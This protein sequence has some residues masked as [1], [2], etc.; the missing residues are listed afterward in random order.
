MES[1]LGNNTIVILFWILLTC[2]ISEKNE[3]FICVMLSYTIVYIANFCE[4]VPT[5]ATLLCLL[6]TLF[7][8]FELLIDEV[9]RTILLKFHYMVV[10]FC[11]ILI[12]QYGLIPYLGS[13]FFT[14]FIARKMIPI[15]EIRVLISGILLFISLLIVSKQPYAVASFSK[16]KSKIDNILSFRTF[17]E[18]HINYD[19]FMP[20]LYIEDKTFISRGDSYSILNEHFINKR[21]FRRYLKAGLRYL[22]ANGIKYTLYKFLRGYSTIEMQLVRTLGIAEGYDKVVYRKIYEFLYV[23]IFLVSLRNYYEK[24]GLSTDDYKYFLLYIYL[25]VAPPLQVRNRAVIE[26]A[27]NKEF[28]ELE[29]FTK[30]EIFVLG[31]TFS[32]KLWRQNVFDLYSAGIDK[33]KLDYKTLLSIKEKIIEANNF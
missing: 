11:Y 25:N 28:R 12:F 20:L 22:K 31:L 6:M 33:Y 18:K 30:E 24:C 8:Y 29:S 4:I 1:I 10:D 15:D 23:R 5:M 26:K 21:N 7:V 9:K 2:I 19:I 27:F 14:T 17:K 32:G 3:A 16:M 13:V